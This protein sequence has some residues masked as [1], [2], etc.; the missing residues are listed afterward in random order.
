MTKEEVRK[1]ERLGWRF[2]D[3]YSILCGEYVLEFK[4][5][6]MNKFQIL[7]FFKTADWKEN[8]DKI[9]GEQL[10]KE[11]SKHVG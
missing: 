6:R 3:Y 9:D 8:W 5:P 10:I 4:S 7:D 2:S 11:E 1:Y